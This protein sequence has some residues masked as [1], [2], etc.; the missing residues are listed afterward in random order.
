MKI[1]FVG[2]FRDP[3]STH[4]PMVNELRR[5]KNKVKLFEFRNFNQKFSKIW[6]KKLNIYYERLE[7]TLKN[8]LILP[9][10]IRNLRYFLFGNWD[11]NRRLL[12]EVKN[13][14][15]DLVFLA[16]AE[17]INYRI[18]PKINKYA[19]TW[20]YFMDPLNVSFQM[21]AHKYASL[22]TW[23]SASTRAMNKLFIKEGANSYFITQGIDEKIFKPSF[24]NKNKEI[25]V[26]FAGSVDSK[27]KKYVDYLR[28][29]GVKITCFGNGWKNKPIYLNEL[30]EKYQKSKIVLNFP[31]EDS[32][33]SIRVFQVMGVG[34]FLLSE[35]CSDL[36]YI[37]KKGVHLDY[38]KNSKECL[39]LVNY[40]LENDKVREKIAQK[41]HEFVLNNFTW[42]H[43]I[44]KILKI[45]ETQN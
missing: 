26:I 45:I 25:D 8:S 1:L 21:N 18:I 2:T 43:I 20:Y 30:V 6:Y 41:G 9:I 29:N 11:I 37:F 35:Y 13:N 14:K 40:Y 38:F 24:E 4:F 10:K 34:S 12:N 42:K 39:D 7:Y 28:K 33:F 17:N 32:G 5:K 31:R 36:K 44:E 3:W 15:Y 27:R 23:S 16:K 22:S 19:R